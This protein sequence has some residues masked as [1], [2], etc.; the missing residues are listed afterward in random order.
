MPNLNLAK[1]VKSKPEQKTENAVN[2]SSNQSNGTSIESFFQFFLPF[3]LCIQTLHPFSLVFMLSIIA[4]RPAGE[5]G[6][7]LREGGIDRDT[8]ATHNT[9]ALVFGYN[10]TSKSTE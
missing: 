1:Y 10:F 6:G 4:T 2:Q 9:W 7:T 5:H 8:V 3:P